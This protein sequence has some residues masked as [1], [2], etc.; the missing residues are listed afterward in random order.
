MTVEYEGKE[1]CADK[2]DSYISCKGCVFDQADVD[3]KWCACKDDKMKQDCYSAQI[4]WK[5]VSAP[6]LKKVQEEEP[7][8]TVEQ[9][10]AATGKHCDEKG[11]V[12]IN[13]KETHPTAVTWIKQH[14]AQQQD[15]EYQLY[16]KLKQKYEQ[17]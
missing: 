15:P 2:E 10:L 4:V 13:F 6:M 8:F 11:P 9:V 17:A 7:K 1:Y 16:V 3:Y 12:F 14:L 5:E